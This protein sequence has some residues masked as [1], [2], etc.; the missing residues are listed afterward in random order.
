M[1]HCPRCPGNPPRILRDMSTETAPD[2]DTDE[3]DIRQVISR[4]HEL[5]SEPASFVALHTPAAVVVNLPGRRVLGRDA[6]AEAMT[7]ALASPLESVRT[8][9]EII[10]L[11]FV[12]SNVAVVSCTKTIHDD[13]SDDDKAKTALPSSTGALTYVMVRTNDAWRIALAQTTPIA[14][15]TPQ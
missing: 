13:R 8:S 6:L 11:R 14:E 12:T 4:A 1:A 9:V 3:R 7:A 5:Q 2:A 15:S 10:D